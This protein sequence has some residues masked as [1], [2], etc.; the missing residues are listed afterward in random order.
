VEDDG[1]EK[2][3]IF[4]AGGKA[5]RTEDAAITPGEEM[6]VALEKEPQMGE[7]LGVK[8]DEN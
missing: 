2:R 5:Y 4:G 6:K 8:S 7:S 3:G 1:P